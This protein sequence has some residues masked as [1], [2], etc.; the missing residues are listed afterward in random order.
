MVP[1]FV[2]PLLSALYIG[3]AL[4]AEVAMP[5]A[6]EN[7]RHP[8]KELF[9]VWICKSITASDEDQR[10]SLPQRAQASLSQLS[11]EDAFIVPTIKDDSVRL[12][13]KTV[14]MQNCFT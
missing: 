9:E 1:S 6:L 2:V 10:P 14:Q 12:P 11:A 8:V 13:P 5:R 3:F 4:K 7:Y